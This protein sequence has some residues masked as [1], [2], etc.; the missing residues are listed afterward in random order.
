MPSTRARRRG[1]AWEPG[2]DGSGQLPSVRIAEL[3]QNAASRQ[4]RLIGGRGFVG[5]GE[6]GRLR[7]PAA[8]AAASEAS[9]P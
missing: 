8:G 1:S 3:G 6:D 7:P 9:R 4:S 5:A 2:I